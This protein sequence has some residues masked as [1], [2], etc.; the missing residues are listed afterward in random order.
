M[1]ILTT[2]AAKIVLDAGCGPAESRI[3]PNFEG[4]EWA[5]L[6]VDADPSVEPDLI[7]QVWNLQGVADASIDAVWCKSVIDHL[8][9]DQ[10]AKMLREFH[11]V[12]VPGGACL[13]VCL[14][15]EKL[16]RAV[17][18]EGLD[19][20][21]YE[22]PI[23]PVSAFDQ[24]FGFKPHVAAGNPWIL[25]RS[26]WTRPMLAKALTEAGFQSGEVK[27]NDDFMSEAMMAVAIK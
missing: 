11:R 13:I 23:G 4:P 10:A 26:G 18:E 27:A 21:R 2:T 17:L 5:R 7:A 16:C 8:T 12:L 1:N 20:T 6:R 22:S 14:D 15:F 19:S 3:H 24:I 9:W 25:K